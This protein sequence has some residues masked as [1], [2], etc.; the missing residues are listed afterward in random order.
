MTL[1]HPENAV[2][3]SGWNIEKLIV[4]DSVNVSIGAYN[5]TQT[6]ID[7][8]SYGYSEPPKFLALINPAASSLWFLSGGGRFTASVNLIVQ[9]TTTTLAARCIGSSASATV[10]FWVFDSTIT[11]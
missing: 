10:K 3:Y 6:L 7:L 2:F 1:L 8:S 5:G 11:S 4:H 9:A